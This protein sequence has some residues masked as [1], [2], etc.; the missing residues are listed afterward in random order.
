MMRNKNKIERSK[1]IWFLN[2][3]KT[4]IMNWKIMKTIY[5]KAKSEF[6]NYHGWRSF[7]F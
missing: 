4:L 6:C 1:Y 5:S 3:N 2:E 7:I